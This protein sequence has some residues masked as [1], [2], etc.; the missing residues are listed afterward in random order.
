MLTSIL[1]GLRDVRTPL[2]CGYMWLVAA[3]LAF[4]DH[5]PR[6]RPSAGMAASIWDLGGH[7][8]KAAVLAAITFAA[9]LIGAVLEFDP[10]R[11][12]RSIGVPS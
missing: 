10:T 2:A 3:W 5:L 9:Y 7:L 6:T 12:W 8:G 11:L 4:A 1:P